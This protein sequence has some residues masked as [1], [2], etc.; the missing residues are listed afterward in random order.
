MV[1]DVIE[2]ELQLF[3]GIVQSGAVV[4]ANLGPAGQTRLDTVAGCVEWDFTRQ[5]IYEVGA[6][7]PRPDEA[8]LALQYVEELRQLVD[9]IASQHASYAGDSVIVRGSPARRSVVLRIDAHAAKFC[10]PEKLAALPHPFLSV[11]DGKARF[12][13]YQHC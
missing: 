1:L 2:I 4:V 10:N 11:K 13:Q 8:H 5:L 7:R 3:G 6:L 12:E 9:S